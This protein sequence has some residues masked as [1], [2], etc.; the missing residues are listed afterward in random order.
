M[1]LAVFLI[2]LHLKAMLP[3]EQLGELAHELTP[4]CSFSSSLPPKR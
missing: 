4:A 1:V 3:E 2:G